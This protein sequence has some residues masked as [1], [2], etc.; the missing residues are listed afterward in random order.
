MCSLTVDT[1]NLFFSAFPIQN[2]ACRPAELITFVTTDA[3]SAQ[4]TRRKADELIS[5]C[6]H[7]WPNGA[8]P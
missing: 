2:P 5:L 3:S 6:L 1:Q 7:P 4:C 8:L